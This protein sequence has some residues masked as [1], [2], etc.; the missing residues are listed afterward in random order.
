M[1]TFKIYKNLDAIDRQEKKYISKLEARINAVQNRAMKKQREYTDIEATKI[2][3]F[4]KIILDLKSSHNKINEA[5]A[6]IE[7]HIYGK[8]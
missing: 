2:Q 4:T 1:K 3:K 7:P 8:Y 6:I 5:M